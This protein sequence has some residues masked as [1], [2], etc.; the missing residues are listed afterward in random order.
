[1]LESLID[2]KLAKAE[3]KR[4]GITVDDKEMA[5]ALNNFKK[6]NNLQDDEAFNKALSQAGL[7]L[8]ELKQNWPT[9]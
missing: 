2:Q 4:R 6:K 7:S 9:R 8:K 1:M 3:A 5:A